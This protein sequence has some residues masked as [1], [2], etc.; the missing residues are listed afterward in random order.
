MRPLSPPGR[1]G[2]SAR[3]TT[4]SAGACLPVTKN[5]NAPASDHPHECGFVVDARCAELGGDR[6]LPLHACAPRADHQRH[7]V[8]DHRF[9]CSRDSS[10]QWLRARPRDPS[11]AWFMLHTG[12]AATFGHQCDQRQRAVTSSKT[13][14]RG[15][16]ALAASASSGR[17]AILGENHDRRQPFD[18]DS[19]RFEPDLR[20]VSSI[21]VLIA[22]KAASTVIGEGR[23]IRLQRTADNAARP[24][25]AAARTRSAMYQAEGR[26]H[27]EAASDP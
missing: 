25:P 14:A 12:I 27:A 26:K 7:I 23:G 13:R 19:C 16:A 3:R 18:R 1:P 21:S 9:R 6:R 24:L 11:V 22:R 4:L 20:I 2:C 15:Q 8:G 17:M 5:A 10:A